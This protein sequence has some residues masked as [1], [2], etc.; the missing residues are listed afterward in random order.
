M[1]KHLIARYRLNKAGNFSFLG[2]TLHTVSSLVP[3]DL[4]S[5]SLPTAGTFVQSAGI[6]IGGKNVSLVCF[7]KE[8][9]YQ[10]A[11]PWALG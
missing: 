9:Q 11:G 10:E 2:F 5:V 1:D 3:G 4:E 6:A 7:L 8:M